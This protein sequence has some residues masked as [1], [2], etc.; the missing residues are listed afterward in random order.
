MSL[1]VHPDRV[2]GKEKDSATKKF[3]TLGRV[4]QILSDSDLRSVYDETGK[5]IL[6]Y[7]P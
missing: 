1:K 6:F 5:K 2:T 4:Y 3:Q 7:F